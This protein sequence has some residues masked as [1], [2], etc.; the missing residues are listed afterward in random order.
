M[1]RT[2][3]RS[4]IAA[5]L[6]D[7]FRPT[8]DSA[9]GPYRSR[10]GSRLWLVPAGIGAV[11]FALTLVGWVVDA[12]QFYFAYLVG[13]TFCLSIALG[14]LF[15][16][17]IQH[18]TR[19]RWSVVV[20]RSAESLA[21]AIPLL[22]LLSI[23][24]FIGMH[25]LFHW[26]HAELHDPTHP[27]YDAL[28]AG[29]SAYLNTP[30]FIIRFVIYFGLW[31]IIS[32]RTYRLSVLQDV[33]PDP[34][35]PAQLR[36]VSAWGLPVLAVTAT[37]ASF[38]L[39][40]SLDPHWF[41]TIFGVYFFA[42]AM[43]ATF[44]ILVLVNLAFQRGNVGLVN[45]VTTE[46][47]HDLGKFMFGFT[48]F[49]AYIAFS[50]YMLIWYGNIPEET[51]WYRHRLEYGWEYNSL[52]LLVMHFIIPFLILLPRSTKRSVPVLAVM[53]VW[54]LIMHWFDLH[55]LALP[56]LHH[57]AMFHWLDFTAWLGL[58]GLFVG[59]FLF[60]LARHSLIPR[61]DPYLS[62]SLH[63]HNT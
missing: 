54:F 22:A 16:V 14:A 13:W 19:A 9:E 62:E 32:Y 58:F 56:V 38:D 5:F 8:A 31:S 35:I 21:A 50:Q 61:N 36:K 2:L 30:F 52:A 55:W 57:D 20:R 4:G 49:W 43:W 44:A 53:G 37:F 10:A 39:L 18:L 28:I 25:D 59:A 29:K 26:T 48:V 17:V 40:M 60:R 51:L 6:L 7:P 46:H 1:A 63:F 45:V 34:L 41:S 24:I 27:E 3:E 11:F 15:F 23:P 12:P 47:Y 33:A 42:G